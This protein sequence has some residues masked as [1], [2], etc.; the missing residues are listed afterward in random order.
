M[1]I[2]WLPL[3]LLMI[4]VHQL[5]SRDLN[6]LLQTHLSLHHTLND[7]LYY[8]N[9]DNSSALIGAAKKGSQKTLRRFLDAGANGRRA[10]YLRRPADGLREHPIPHGAINGHMDIVQ[11]LL[12][13][14][15]NINF[16][17]L[18]G[19][20]PLALAA[21]NGH[22][23]LCFPDYPKFTIPSEIQS[24][25]WYAAKHGDQNRIKYLMKMGAD[26]NFQ[27]KFASST[28]LYSAVTFA[29]F[30]VDVVKLLLEF[31]ADPNICTAP[32]TRNCIRGIVPRFTLP[33]HRA[34][35]KNES[36]ILI[37]LLLDF[38]THTD[39]ETLFAALKHK[40]SAEFRILVEHGGN[41]YSRGLKK[42]LFKYALESPCEDIRNVTLEQRITPDT[43][44]P[45]SRRY[46]IR[47][48]KRT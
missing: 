35:G 10:P 8:C 21:L 2:L 43:P 30:L 23:A 16:K 12:H 34:I 32:S 27:F 42:S 5:D 44:D 41:I 28:P 22:F 11:L 29:P 1:S 18:H 17:D 36:Y 38:G 40:K 6:A 24:M 20:S 3:E 47:R 13:K 48:N 15:A 39:G 7:Y 14:G 37:K 4:I 25:L 46:R 31:G 33:I 9:I 26:V 19:R 45:Y